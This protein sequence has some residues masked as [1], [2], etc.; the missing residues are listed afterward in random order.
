MFQLRTRNTVQLDA[1]QEPQVQA[2]RAVQDQ[3]A[4]RDQEFAGSLI[5]NFYR[6]GRLSERQ[7]PWVET[8]IQRVNQ[9]QPVAQEMLNFA[10]IQALFDRAQQRLK[11][12]RVRL[13]TADGTPVV[14]GRAGAASRYAGQVMIT[15]GLPYG[16]NRFFGRIDTNGDLFPAPKATAPVLALVREFAADPAAT[17]ARY[18]QLTGGCSFCN[19]GLK[20]Q[21]STQVGYGPVCAKNFG[22]NWG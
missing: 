17:A 12:V 19:H 3:L 4:P 7:W 1:A 5:Q 20:D 18:G 2:L 16:Q 21:R 10:P 11:R 22:L 13:Q 6:T 14:L 9:P 8:L 15:D